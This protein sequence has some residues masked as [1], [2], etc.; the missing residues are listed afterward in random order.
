MKIKKNHYPHNNTGRIRRRIKQIIRAA[1]DMALTD[2]QGESIDGKKETEDK[3][4][5]ARAFD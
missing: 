1:G 4:H 5:P 3:S 2:F